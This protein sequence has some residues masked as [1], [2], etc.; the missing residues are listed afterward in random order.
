MQCDWCWQTEDRCGEKL[1]NLAI[2][3]VI[4]FSTETQ[5]LRLNQQIHKLAPERKVGS[6]RLFIICPPFLFFY[7]LEKG[8]PLPSLARS[9]FQEL[10]WNVFIELGVTD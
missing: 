3:C 7:S 2:I 4:I 8:Y 10:S 9:Y 5:I 6:R 1:E